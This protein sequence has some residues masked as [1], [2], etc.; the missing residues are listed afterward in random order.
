MKTA[1]LIFLSAAGMLY[2]QT[3][4]SDAM[5]TAVIDAYAARVNDTVIT[6]GEIRASVAPYVQQLQRQLSGREL[7]ERVAAAYVEGRE[8]L[9]EEAL[10]KAEAKAQAL[11]LPPQ[12]VDEEMDRLIRERFDGDRALLTRALVSRRMTMDEWKAEIGDQMLIR[13]YY[14]QEV[15]RRA[16]IS[17]QAVRTE[18]EKNRESYFTPLRVRYSFI[19]INKGRTDADRSVKKEQIEATLEKLK[20]G[21]DFDTVAK[22]VSA[23]DT[24]VSAWKTLSSIPEEFHAALQTMPA[25]GI[26]DMIETSGEYY[27]LHLVERDAGGYIPFEDARKSIEDRLLQ[28][29]RNRLHQELIKRLSTRHFVE[30]Y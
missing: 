25:N 18:Y 26:S 1:V 29:E 16:S 11:S 19:L 13:I 2:A 10:I 14:A 7:T 12:A 20:S 27:I 30:R 17:Q 3:N 9:I 21:T 5:Q 15:T 24:S 4:N 8:A 6:Y 23:G 22:E 28:S